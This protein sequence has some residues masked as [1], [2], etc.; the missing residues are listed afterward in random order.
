VCPRCCC[1]CPSRHK[2][3]AS[4]KVR[5]A[6]C[7]GHPCE[8]AEFGRSSALPCSTARAVAP[9]LPLKTSIGRHTA[10]IRIGTRRRECPPRLSNAETPEPKTPSDWR[11]AN[12]PRRTATVQE[13]LR[14]RAI[15]DASPL[16]LPPSLAHSAATWP[17]P[18]CVHVWS[19]PDPQKVTRR[20]LWTWMAPGGPH[21]AR[22][23]TA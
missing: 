10:Q 13:A 22:S 9:H 12:P 11:P 14:R 23:K 6:P 4:E 20:M 15:G 2:G 21:R 3:A 5:A 1:R 7:R 17:V 16:S 19:T 18:L 8:V